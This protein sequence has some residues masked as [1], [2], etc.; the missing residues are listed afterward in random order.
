MMVLG[1]SMGTNWKGHYTTSLLD[2]YAH[3]RLTRP[4]DL[5]ET[6][7]M[8]TMFG[9]YMRDHY[10]GRYYAKAQNLVRSLTAAYD[11]AFRDC[12]LLVMPTIP[13]KATKIPPPNASREE[14]VTRALEMIPNTSPF[15]LTGHPAINVPCGMSE[16]LPVGM[17]LVGRNGEDATVL[18][19][20]DAFERQVYA[21]PIP[22]SQ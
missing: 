12:D 16:G 21:A 15:D 11:A 17:M 1:N 9:C 14:Y 20:A 3:G 7:K 2:A 13:L 5:S 4:N 22:K 19:A 18:R 10:H 6:V 8:F